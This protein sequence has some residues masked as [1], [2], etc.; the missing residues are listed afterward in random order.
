MA[1]HSKQKA[2]LARLNRARQ[3]QTRNVT[4]PAPEVSYSPSDR[5]GASYPEFDPPS[6]PPT[7]CEPLNDHASAQDEDSELSSEESS[8][9]DDGESDSSAEEMSEAVGAPSLG[10]DMGSVGMLRWTN[11]AEKAKTSKR[12]YGSGSDSTEKRRRRHQR[13]L[14]EAAENT[15]NISDL[16]K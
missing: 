5:P 12:P 2:H 9:D 7:P 6:D 14:G 4:V 16:F 1:R 3:L 10:S 8:S 11:E 15:L 13:E